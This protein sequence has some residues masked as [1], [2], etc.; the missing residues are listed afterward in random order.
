MVGCIVGLLSGVNAIRK[1]QKIKAGGREFL[2]IADITNLIVNLQDAKRNLSHE[3]F[4]AVYSVFQCL[5]K[6]R[7]KLEFDLYGYYEQATIIIGV[8]NQIAPYEKYSGMEKTEALFFMDGIMPILEDLKPKSEAL[9]S[10]LI[11][12]NPELKKFF[13]FK[14]QDIEVF[15]TGLV[16]GRKEKGNDKYIDYMIQN[17]HYLKKEHATAFCG[18]LVAND[19][20]GKDTA[21][22]LMDK[23]FMKWINS[24]TVESIHGPVEGW[25]SHTIAFLCGVLYPNEIVT[26]DESDQLS[27]YYSDLWMQHYINLQ[28]QGQH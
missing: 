17:C 19:L 4:S 1:L 2:S 16:N 12:N 27:E 15:L 7:T 25:M 9:L 14:D 26:K 5:M 28:K 6:C 23:L 18:V 11:A 24:E 20:Y 21:L 13:S 22:D 10:G 3:Q 8:F